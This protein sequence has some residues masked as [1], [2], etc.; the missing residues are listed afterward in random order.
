MP[1]RDYTSTTSI[2]HTFK[3]E[4]ARVCL[5]STSAHALYDSMFL[6]EFTQ[7][8]KPLNLHWDRVRNVGI[9]K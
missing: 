8:Q 7:Q 6:I 2:S 1:I 3:S 4:Q 9:R 5:M